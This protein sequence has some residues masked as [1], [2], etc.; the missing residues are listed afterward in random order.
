MFRVIS[1]NSTNRLNSKP[2]HCAGF[3]YA[4]E[5]SR[6]RCYSPFR[7]IDTEQHMDGVTILSRNYAHLVLQTRNGRLILFLRPWNRDRKDNPWELPFVALQEGMDGVASLETKITNLLPDLKLGSIHKDACSLARRAQKD[8]VA[9]EILRADIEGQIEEGI[10]KNGQVIL[11]PRRELATL[12]S[13]GVVF[14][15]K[16]LVS[17]FSKVVIETLV[18]NGR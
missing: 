6:R 16:Y 10:G 12:T 5:I 14:Y 8:G 11:I 4:H 1:A 18:K 3:C 13:A 7:Y 17:E 15:E 2:A 9:H